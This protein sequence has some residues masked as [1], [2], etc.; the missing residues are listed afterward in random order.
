MPERRGGAPARLSQHIVQAG[1]RLLA[2]MG[3]QGDQLPATA[4][5]QG[6]GFRNEVRL[7]LECL[8]RAFD[9]TSSAARIITNRTNWLVRLI[10]DRGFRLRARRG[11]ERGLDVLGSKGGHA[12]S[13][14]LRART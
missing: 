13:I 14:R 1:G 6:F 5:S 11:R 9:L 7:R 8:S 2:V 4:R 10:G 12:H 3:N